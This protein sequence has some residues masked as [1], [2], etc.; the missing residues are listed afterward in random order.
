MKNILLALSGAFL[1]AACGSEDQQQSAAKVETAIESTVDAAVASTG[2]VLATGAF[3]GRSQHV[4]TGGVSIR[5]TDD[6][7]FVDLAEDFSL[8]GAPD[9]TLGFGNPD[10]ITET[11]FSALLKKDGF[12][13]YKLPDGVDPMQY[14]TIYV[15]CEEF[16]VPLGVATLAAK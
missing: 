9:P 13:S 4:T 11:Q 14:E 1:L 8:D 12:Q 7:Y 6:G 5:K 15:W 16:S 2:Q 3:E 10:F